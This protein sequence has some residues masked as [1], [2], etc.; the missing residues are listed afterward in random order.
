MFINPTAKGIR[1]IPR[2]LTKKE[3]EEVAIPSGVIVM[4]GGSV[5]SIPAGWALCDGNNGTYDLRN[6]F[7]VGAG[8]TYDPGDTGGSNSVTLSTQQIPSHRHKL[9]ESSAT[10]NYQTGITAKS[11]LYASLPN[12][13][14]QNEGGSTSHENRPPFYALAFIQKL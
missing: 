9:E 2:V 12:R 3:K 14:T 11:Y 1:V 7:I 4:W 13:Y 6:L 8:D 5:A 10:L